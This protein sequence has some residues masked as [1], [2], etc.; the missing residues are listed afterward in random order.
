MTPSAKSEDLPKVIGL[1][2]FIP[3]ITKLFLTSSLIVTDVVDVAFVVT[4][5]EASASRA[6]LSLPVLAVAKEF[7]ES[8]RMLL[9]EGRKN[10]A[11]AVRP[12]K[13]VFF[14]LIISLSIIY[15]TCVMYKLSTKGLLSYMNY[16]I[17]SHYLL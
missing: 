17:L 15:I 14:I 7:P 16:S 1:P 12:N 6:R 9:Q 8:S 3:V 4:Q 2:F 5:T 13:N 11:K 10:N